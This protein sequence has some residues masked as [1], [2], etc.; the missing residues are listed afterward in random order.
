MAPLRRFRC[1]EVL[2]RTARLLTATRRHYAAHGL[3]VTVSK[4]ATWLRQRIDSYELRLRAAQPVKRLLIRVGPRPLRILTY[5]W[6]VPHQYELWKLRCEVTLATG[7]GSRF[8]DEWEYGQRP[9]PHNAR[10]RSLADLDTRDFD[11]A[12][13]HFDEN[14]LAPENTNGVIGPDWGAAFKLFREQ[15]DLPK[16]A[17]CHGTPQFYGQY[18]FDYVGADLMQTIEPERQRLVEYLGDIHVVCNSYQAQS[19]WGFRH[20]SVI[21]HGFDPVEFP[22]TSYERGILSPLGSLVLSRPHYRGYFLYKEVFEGHYDQLCPN[23]LQVPE[24]RSRVAGNA[25]AL[26]KFHC[27]VNELSR[28]SVY[29]NPTLRSPMPRAR[30]EAMMCGLVTVSARNHDVDRFIQNGVNGFFADDADELR[31]QLYFLV[32]NPDATRRIGAESRATA[33]KL[34][35]IKRYLS[36][37]SQ[38]LARLV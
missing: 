4:V 19:E 30:G 5:R 22:S 24:P 37:W 2:A 23:A 27:Y 18:T 25:H 31:A 1:T 29:F 21:W 34:F 12:I 33:L 7:T 20:S 26:A 38:L 35:H 3:R 16:I 6:H 28:Y 36:D 15:I 11:I 8:A 17:I 13:L 14:V 32:R 9:L 10:F